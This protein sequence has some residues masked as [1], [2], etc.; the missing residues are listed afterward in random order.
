M[1]Q[2]SRIEG[3]TSKA[4]DDAMAHLHGQVM[5]MG[6]L[7]LEQVRDAV[8]SYAQWDAA[9]AHQVLQRERAVNTYDDRLDEDQMALIAMRQPVAADLRAVVA[10]SKSVADLERAGDEAKKIARAVL[11]EAGRP[12]EA[13]SRDV[14]YLGRLATHLL[15]LAL[16]AFSS[17]DR[18][19]AAAVVAGDRN[20]DSE[21][22]AALRRLLARLGEDPRQFEVALQAAFVLK[23]LERIGDHARNLGRYLQSIDREN[24]ER[25]RSP[26]AP[27]GG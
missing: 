20:L 25:Q 24:L 14:Q 18:D 22:A 11:G 21:Y 9:A 17:L 13:T 5:L 12:D 26:G 1:S 15:Q 27:S 6:R 16:G 7:V 8:R 19:E 4:Y 2:G 10:M 23:S 3:H